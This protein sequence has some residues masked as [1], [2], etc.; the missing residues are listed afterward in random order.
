MAAE[1][2]GGRPYAWLLLAAYWT[3]GGI[4]GSLGYWSLLQRTA[5]TWPALQVSSGLYAV[6]FA[7]GAIAFL[8]IPLYLGAFRMGR[9][10]SS[11]SLILF[12]LANAVLE[13]FVLLFMFDAGR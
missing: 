10:L 6:L 8:R 9:P 7:L 5:Q 2:P 4:A 13:G 3:L 1:Y 12:S 11:V